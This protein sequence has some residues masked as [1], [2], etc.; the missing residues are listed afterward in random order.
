M[1]KNR[2]L[3]LTIVLLVTVIG[4]LASSQAFALSFTFSDQD[5]L[6]DVSWGTLTIT[7]FN[8]HTLQVYYQAAGDSDIPKNSKVTGFGFDFD[9]ILPKWVVNP[10]D[11]TFAD[12][13]NKLDWLALTNLNAIP[14]AANRDEFSPIVDKR[15]FTYGVT[16]G[17]SNGFSPP[18]IMPGESDYFYLV[19]EDD[20]PQDEAGLSD[21]VKLTGI[22]IQD[23][24]KCVND[25]SLFLVGKPTGDSAPVP[26]PSTILLMG[27]G[28]IGV[29]FGARKRLKK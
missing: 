21:F 17:K 19:F 2:K 23:L 15:D 12:D 22:R 26:E 29:A 3:H 6:N 9:S 14:Q 24:S 27:M 11:D 5:I 4:L 7:P 1:R 18:G 8:D 20:V 16:E 28:V 13:E 25:G 10:L